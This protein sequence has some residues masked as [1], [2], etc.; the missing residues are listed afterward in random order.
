MDTIFMII[1]VYGFIVSLPIILV[2]LGNRR[3]NVSNYKAASGKTFSNLL[4][5]KGCMGEYQ[6]YKVLER[7]EENNKI[8]TNLYIPRSN[9]QLTEIDLIMINKKGI[10]VFES[11]D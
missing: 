10:F 8:L 6:L 4:F 11:K 7:L 2:Y 5:E 1:F 3:Y 9:G